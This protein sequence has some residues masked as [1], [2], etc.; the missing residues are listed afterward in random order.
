MHPIRMLARINLD[1]GAANRRRLPRSLQGD[2]RNWISAEAWPVTPT[3]APSSRASGTRREQATPLPPRRIRRNAVIQ[4]RTD[5]QRDA[6][7]LQCQEMLSLG[8]EEVPTGRRGNWTTEAD[9]T[10]KM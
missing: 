5:K 4:A 8:S 2:S 1:V 10:A 9:V 7:R 3:D 6:D